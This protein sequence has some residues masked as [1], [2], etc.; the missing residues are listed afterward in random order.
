MKLDNKILK[1][2]ITSMKTKIK[3]SAV[4]MKIG[5]QL[6]NIDR[7]L[8]YIKKSSDQKSEIV[9]FP[10]CSFNGNIKKPATAKDLKPILLAAR[11]NNIYVIINGYFKNHKNGVS[12]RT[13][14]IDNKGKITGFYDKIYPWT[15]EKNKISRGEKIKVLKTPLGRI[16]LCTC[17]DLFF[18]DMFRQLKKLGAELVFC[19]SYW[20]DNLKKEG[21]YLEYIPTCLSYTHMNYFIYCNAILKGKTSITQITSP[22]GELKKIKYRE[23]IISAVLYSN[24]IIRFK[25]K[26]RAVTWGR[27]I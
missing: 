8:G 27:I 3:V 21:V 14:L 25:N 5:S 16:G 12:N 11:K 10:E 23:G 24:R 15:T 1:V 6:K 26:F 22:W 4:Q 18:P 20:N 13:Y 7:I 19:P 17:W 2:T 9:C